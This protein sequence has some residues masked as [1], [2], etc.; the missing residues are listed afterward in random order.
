[1]SEASTPPAA[2]EPIRQKVIDQLCERFAQDVIPVTEFER[3]VDLAHKAETPSDLAAL[4]SDLPQPANLPATT[5][6][7]EV[8]SRPLTQS[9]A[10][11]KERDVMVGI[12][13]GA[14]RRG[15]WTPAEK[16]YAGGIMGGVEL[17]FREAILPPDGVEVTVIAVMGGAEIIVP[18]GVHVDM[19]GVAIMGGFDHTAD[20]GVMPNP[21]APTRGQLLTCV[22]PRS[23]SDL[24]N[25]SEHGGRARTNG[26]DF[27]AHSGPTQRKIRGIWAA[28]PPAQ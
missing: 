27:E 28:L 6:G 4:L 26:H 8:A 17:D 21:D 20:E 2:L 9:P 1:M 19:G 12:F 13:G 14:S 3:R 11:V 23:L 5:A 24:G 18:P 7:I 16:I 15:R 22:K 10:K 25:R